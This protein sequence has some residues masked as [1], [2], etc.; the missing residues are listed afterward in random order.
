RRETVVRLDEE[1]PWRLQNELW[2]V[3]TGLVAVPFFVAVRASNKMC[4]GLIPQDFI[5]GGLDFA[6]AALNP[7]LNVESETRLEGR[8]IS[9]QS[10]DLRSDEERSTRP[11]AG[12]PVRVALA[13]QPGVELASDATGRVRVDLL[14]LFE[15]APG[16]AP[17]SLRVEVAGDGLRSPAA[18]ELPLSGR[19]R[20]RLL[21]GAHERAAARAPE[22]SAETAARA[23]VALD[24][25]GFRDSAQ[26]L[27]RELREREQANTAWLARLDLAL[28]E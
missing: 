6:F 1:T 3:P 4:L 15:G 7:L 12:V 22:A 21:E 5:D 10:R 26:T 14:A 27:E 24:A 13:R 25:L 19:I 16:A 11:L 18:L 23:L 28:S 17:R 8:E 9:R 2:E 20:A